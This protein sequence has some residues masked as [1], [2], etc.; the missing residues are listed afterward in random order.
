M[1]EHVLGRL[2]ELYGA[3]P[4]S[5]LA[6]QFPRLPPGLL[7]P[8]RGLRGPPGAPLPPHGRPLVPRL[9]DFGEAYRRAAAGL[10]GRSP[11]RPAPPGHP[12]H[13][14]QTAESLR[15]ENARLARENADL[16][17]RLGPDAGG[18]QGGRPGGGR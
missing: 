13:R 6:L 10:A 17:R 1:D 14:A 7:G 16:R 3:S 2:R 12:L 8:G 4:E 9:E 5:P 18:P 11:A 15:A